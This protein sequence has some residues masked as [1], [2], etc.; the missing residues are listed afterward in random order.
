[1][2]KRI[3]KLADMCRDYHRDGHGNYIE[4]FD[5]EKFAELIVRDC[6]T[7]CETVAL[8]AECANSNTELARKTKATAKSCADLM[9]MHFG[10]E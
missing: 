3:E 4:Q 6:I 10:V 1:M 8:T 2:N 7:L 9:K 5:E